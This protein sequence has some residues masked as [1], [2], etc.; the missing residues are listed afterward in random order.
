MVDLKG[1]LAVHF[2]FTKL[3]FYL[4]IT[5]KLGLPLP[6]N[7]FLWNRGGSVNASSVIH[8]SEA[9]AGLFKVSEHN[10]QL[11]LLLTVV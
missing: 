5:S 8:S 2:N 3:S 1:D 6:V 7:L 11:P 9:T 10:R 4:Y